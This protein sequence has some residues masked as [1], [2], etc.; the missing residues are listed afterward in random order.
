M[1]TFVP[2]AFPTHAQYQD[3]NQ[4]L[5]KHLGENEELLLA[6]VTLGA[7][8]YVSKAGRRAISLVPKNLDHGALSARDAIGFMQIAIKQLQTAIMLPQARQ[9]SAVLY[10]V[11]CL[12]LAEVLADNGPA[13][14]LHA[15]ALRHLLASS[16]I[17]DD[18]PT[19]VLHAVIMTYYIACAISGE[20]PISLPTPI[21]Q[22]AEPS[23]QLK[24]SVLHNSQ[25]QVA[26]LGLA[27]FSLDMQTILGP[28]LTNAFQSMRTFTL[29]KEQHYSDCPQVGPDEFN[30]FHSWCWNSLHLVLG[31]P[32]QEASLQGNDDRKGSLREPCRIALLVFWLSITELHNPGSM[33]YRTLA[34]RLKSALQRCPSEPPAWTD[35]NMAVFWLLLLG[36]SITDGQD[37]YHWFLT[38]IAEEMRRR[39]NSLS[40]EVIE[41][42]VARFLYMEK[43]FRAGFKDAWDRAVQ[44]RKWHEGCYCGDDFCRRVYDR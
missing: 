23:L 31:L 38:G 9:S 5:V 17:S 44:L 36:A 20:R 26:K 11:A 32:Y 14:Q 13:V 2:K 3:H 34:L 37:E 15:T 18:I 19:H 10:S 39:D 29:W 42:V 30:Y 40:W 25:F 7:T 4:W 27:F 16:R 8:C 6:I 41:N 1:H 33:I 22:V 21:L 24:P 12:T 43:L 35:S 28:E